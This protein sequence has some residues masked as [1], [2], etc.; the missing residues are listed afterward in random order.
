MNGKH[1]LDT[2][3]IVALFKNDE[4]VRSQIASAPEVFVPSIAVGELYYGAQHSAQV[5]RNVAQVREF[6]ANSAVLACDLVTAEHYGQ[7]KNELKTK[8]RPLPENDVWIAAIASQ[9]SLTVVTRDQHFGVIDGL[10]LEEW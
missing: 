5:E 6:A 7:I 3:I 4:A 9:H 10:Q 2:S 8:G 1:R